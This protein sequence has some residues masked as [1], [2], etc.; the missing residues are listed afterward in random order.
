VEGDEA[1]DDGEDNG[2]FLNA[3]APDC[4]RIIVKKRI[5]MS[6]VVHGGNLQPN[7]VAAADARCPSG[8]RAMFVYG[9]DRRATTR[10]F[11]SIEPIDWAIQPYTYYVNASDSLVWIT[12]D[13]PLLGVENGQF[14]GLEGALV[15]VTE[16]FASN[17]NIDG[18][19]MTA[20]NCDGWTT[21]D[22]DVTKQC[23]LSLYPNEAY[24]AFGSGRCENP[25][26][27]YCFER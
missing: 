11:E 27:F 2:L 25:L 26:V 17:M 7:P 8:Y 9:T 5:V 3:C 12:R 4:S 22:H 21:E 23:G 13:V 1:C 19:T 24:L 6:E 10:P 16:C 18:T 20:D 15:K 14:V